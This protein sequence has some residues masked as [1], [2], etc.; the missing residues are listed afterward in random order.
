MSESYEHA[1]LI[2]PRLWLGNR[3]AAA[4]ADFI[5]MHHIK[6]V[7]NCTKDLPFHTSIQRKYRIPVHD[8]LEPEEINRLQEWSPEIVYKVLAEYNLGHTILVHCHAGMQRSAAV[9]AMVLLTITRQPMDAVVKHI[10]GIRPVAF[11]PAINFESAIRGYE[12]ELRRRL[13]DTS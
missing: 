12:S 6:T 10:R 2:I 7:F 9:V 5:Q 4:D 11:F 1:H 3:H 8:N 13:T